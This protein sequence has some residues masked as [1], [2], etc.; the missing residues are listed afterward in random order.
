VRPRSG[1]EAV[2]RFWRDESGQG[3]LF[4]AASLVVLV[5]FVALVFN[6]GR[7]IERRTRMQLAADAAAYSGAV[8]AANSLSSIAWINSAMAQLY[9]NSIKYAVDVCVSGVAAKMALIQGRRDAAE[10]VEVHRAAW[11]RAKDGLLAAKKRMV[12]LSRVENA[13]AILTPRLV[14]EEMFAVAKRAG[15]ERLSVYPSFRMFPHGS[16]TFSYLIEQFG[17]GWRLTRLS[18]GPGWVVWVYLMGEEWH[19]E[20]SPDGIVYQEVII[21]REAPDRWRIRYYQPP[22][23]PIQEIMLV[24]T[25][26]AGWVVW[27]VTYDDGQATFPE[28]RIEPADMDGDG[29]NEGTRITYQGKSY[30]FRRG[31]EGDLYVWDFD[32]QEYVNA[33]SSETVVEGVT[34]RVNVTNRIHFPGGWA[35]I[36]DPTRV[37]IG[38]A[39]VVLSDPPRIFVDLKEEKKPVRIAVRG[40]DAD[41]FDVSVGGFS[42]RRN[43]ADGRWRKHYDPREELWWRHRLTEERPDSGAER[44]WQYDYQT[45]GALLQ[46]ESNSNL[47]RFAVQHALGDRFGPDAEPEWTRW[48]D[49]VTGRPRNPTWR[50]TGEHFSPPDRNGIRHLLPEFEPPEDA[51]YL[52][53]PCRQCGGTG[54]VGDGECPVCRACDHNGDGLTDVRVF[55]ADLFARDQYA[56]F[57]CN[58]KPDWQEDDYVDARL[59][60][61]SYG[62]PAVQRPLV[63]A[64][65]FFQYGI[66]VGTWMPP[67]VPMLFPED[68]QPE[69]GYVAIAGARVG[70]PDPEAPEGYRYHFPDPVSRE[71]WCR[72]APENLYVADL[73]ARLYPSREQVKEYDLDLDILYSEPLGWGFGWPRESPVSYLWDAILGSSQDYE[74]NNWLD[75]FEGRADP[76]VG[77]RLRNMRDRRGR[78]FDFQD[79]GLENVVEH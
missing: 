79:P 13:I 16:T 67:D 43:Q 40:F 24:K 9:Y 17:N 42:L 66:N 26:A 55:L 23:N 22:G 41:D 64:E 47:R 77:R 19:I 70:V 34:V 27:G 37:N 49:P 46:Y 5:G 73:A 59:H 25:D 69:W 11:E 3:L 39:R 32:R 1:R 12:D 65:E 60:V 7:V 54:R 74:P 31:P 53:E 45:I 75:Q 8:V 68:R 78:R 50:H 30:V 48:F 35:R 63:L 44:Q 58:G 4:A 51:Y 57:L 29:R 38:K 28:V 76:R 36:G 6:F 18:G 72:D 10:A 56:E 20:Y 21:A 61:T 52:T 62:L 2:V 15:A 33:T 14:Q 71:D